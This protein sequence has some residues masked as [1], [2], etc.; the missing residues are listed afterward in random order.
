MPLTDEQRESINSLRVLVEN[1][2]HILRMAKVGSL[3][4]TLWEGQSVEVNEKTQP[5]L[6]EMFDDILNQ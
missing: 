1:Y 6:L 4:I 5:I 2:Q 3:S